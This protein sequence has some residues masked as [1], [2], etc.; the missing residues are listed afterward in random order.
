MCNSRNGCGDV[1]VRCHVKVIIAFTSKCFN[2]RWNSHSVDIKRTNQFVIH[3]RE[4][5][6][7]IVLRQTIRFSLCE[8]MRNDCQTWKMWAKFFNIVIAVATEKKWETPV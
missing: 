8:L 7:V 6:V 2:E 4:S 3:P 5:A 1:S